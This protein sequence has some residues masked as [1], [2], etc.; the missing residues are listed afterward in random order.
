MMLPTGLWWENESNPTTDVLQL[1]DALNLRA[2]DHHM[3][4][5][6]QQTEVVVT[7]PVL[8]LGPWL[9]SS[10]APGIPFS[11]LGPGAPIHR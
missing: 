7:L 4:L 8:P 2:G 3:A 1:D 10:L 6:D 9:P 5:L 11:P